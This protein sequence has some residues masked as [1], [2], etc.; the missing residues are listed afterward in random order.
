M[1]LASS[2]SEC[3]AAE[4]ATHS[5]PPQL[6]ADADAT[7]P[8]KLAPFT[9][10][11]AGVLQLATELLQLTAGDVLV[12]LGCGDARM[13]VHAAQASGCRCWSE[14]SD[15]LLFSVCRQKGCVCM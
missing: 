10:S 13:L 9:P 2:S 11:G 6:S 5:E 7:R 15:S 12:D 8:H 1:E 3:A 14:S 4:P